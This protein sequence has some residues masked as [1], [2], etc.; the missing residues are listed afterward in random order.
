MNADVNEWKDSGWE[1][2]LMSAPPALANVLRP[3]GD[4]AIIGPGGGVDVLRAVANGSPSV[5]GIEINPIIA[6]TVMGDRYAE[7]SQHLYQRPE[8]HIHVTDG[9]SFVRNASQQFDVVQ[10][11]LVDTWASTAAGAFAL[12]ENS[13][14]TEEAFQ[15]YFEH[16][17]PDGMIAITRWEFRQPREALRVVS[18]AMDALHKLG[19]HATSHNFI[20][21]SE[22]DLDEDGIPVAVLAKKSAF[23]PAEEAAVRAHLATYP[24]LVALY[25]PSQHEDN[26]FTKL[27]ASNDPF[28]FAAQYAY[29]VAPVNDNSPF[30]FFTLKFR[31]MFNQESLRQ[32]IDWKVNLG[33]AVLGMVF[34]ISL[35]AVFSFLVVPLLLRSGEGSQRTLP[36]LY[37]VAVGLGYILVEIAFIQRFVLFL[38]H[39][40]YAL[41]VV[42]F[43]LL[44]SSGAGSLASRKWMVQTHR[45]WLPLTLI[46]LALFAY[47]FA[48]PGILN[49]MVGLAFVVKLVI[50]AI[51]LVPLGFA[52][53]IPFPTG[54]RALAN[55]ASQ[56]NSV[57]WAWAMNAASSVLGSVLA[58]VIAIQFG[59]NA[60]LACG[61]VAYFLALLLV[62][63]F[64]IKTAV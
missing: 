10:M 12:S 51:I 19:V 34:I 27:I 15:E 1:K 55:A 37:F 2:S 35:I 48:L 44:L 4:Y 23:T 26:P 40:T 6:N 47:V 53:G 54:L 61:A 62:P 21:V 57:E 58:M 33:V 42:V 63:T 7:Y 9:R 25:T 45:C 28:A 32:G 20:V 18:V 30:F 29:N 13:L 38:G 31:D 43:L 24:A 5:T 49:G 3:H 22:G 17:K 52:M 39:P 56:N 60:T 50:S 16:L 36:L 11:T 59:L 64:Q 41:T 46:I 14:Y 8:V